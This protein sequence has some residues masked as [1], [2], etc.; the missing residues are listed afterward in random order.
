M[1]LS[2]AKKVRRRLGAWRQAGAVPRVLNWLQNGFRL[3]WVRGPPP[4]FHQGN[5]C[6]ALDAE[7]QRF[8]DRETTRLLASGAWEPATDARWVSKA[9]LVPKP[10]VMA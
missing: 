2:L 9:F 1:A 6:T 3:P 4:P 5:S 10:G 7:E 8:L